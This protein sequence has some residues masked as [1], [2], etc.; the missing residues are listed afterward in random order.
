[1]EK[2]KR[3]NRIEGEKKKYKKKGQYKMKQINHV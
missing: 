1:M 3:R 2:T